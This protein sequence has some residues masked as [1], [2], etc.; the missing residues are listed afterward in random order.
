MFGR[1]ISVVVFLKSFLL[2]SKVKKKVCISFTERPLYL[3]YAGHRI[4]HQVFWQLDRAV[5][6]LQVVEAGEPE[7]FQLDDQY[8]IDRKK[9]EEEE[10][11]SGEDS[12]WEMKCNKP[13]SLTYYSLWQGQERT[14]LWWLFSATLAPIL[15]LARLQRG[16]GVRQV[17]CVLV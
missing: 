10:E 11:M 3:F 13:L 15:Q 2:R 9:I 7:A 17:W 14:V 1:L 6:L 8:A 12:R 16:T 5:D 4:H